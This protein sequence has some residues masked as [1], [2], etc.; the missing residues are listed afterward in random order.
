[1]RRA[2]WDMA[3][4]TQEVWQ[5]SQILI[6]RLALRA[7]AKIRARTPVG[8]VDPTTGRYLPT[9]SME[10]ARKAQA[11]KAGV[12][13]GRARGNWNL[14]IGAADGTY[15]WERKDPSGTAQTM[16]HQQQALAIKVGDRVFIA[17]G[18]PY[19]RRLEY[20]WSAQAPEGMVRL[21]FEELKPLCEELALEVRT[22]G[23]AP[24]T[25]SL[26]VQ[27]LYGEAT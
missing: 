3:Q 26:G 21:T 13:S 10:A 2:G 19:I 17:N 27:G 12:P 23:A 14:S 5:R 8:L 25:I 11:A 7:S 20:G 22:G 6:A 24:A 1:M 9:M 4:A 18:L 16:L 15:D